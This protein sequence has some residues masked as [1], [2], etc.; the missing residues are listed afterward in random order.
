MVAVALGGGG[1][2]SPTGAPRPEVPARLGDLLSHGATAAT[3]RP[4]ER[5]ARLLAAGQG[6]PA[7]AIA[8]DVL[9]TCALSNR[10]VLPVYRRAAAVQAGTMRAA[11]TS[12]RAQAQA[13]S[14]R[15][16]A[17]IATAEAIAA[18]SS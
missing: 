5:A 11:P 2:R 4:L 12:V 9:A 7:M 8:G 6:A 18:T 15:G 17:L 13:P 14:E 1:G 10:H 16:H 3:M